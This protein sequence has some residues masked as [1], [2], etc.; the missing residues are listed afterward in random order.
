MPAM[1][2]RGGRLGLLIA[3]LPLIAAAPGLA[4]T[5]SGWIDPPVRPD[6][7][8]QADE[9]SSSRPP[10]LS[11][12]EDYEAPPPAPPAAPAQGA[13]QRPRASAPPTAGPAAPAPAA[14]SG[15]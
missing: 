15:Q 6:A 14:S 13:V 8:A 5:G 10:A 4:Q 9:S 12:E 3:G 1:R 2:G 11:F 7:P